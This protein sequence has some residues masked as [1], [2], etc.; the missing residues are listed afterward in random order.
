MNIK[1]IM[2]IKCIMNINHISI[3]YENMKYI[4]IFHTKGIFQTE[5]IF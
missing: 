2:N 1:Y 4:C 5:N 3:V